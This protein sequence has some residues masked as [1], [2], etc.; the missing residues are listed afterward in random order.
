MK[1]LNKEILIQKEI[2]KFYSSQIHFDI[3]FAILQ[4]KSH[5]TLKIIDF[6]CLKYAKKYNISY[7]YT[8]KGKKERINVVNSYREQLKAYSGEYFT[9]F[10]RKKQGVNNTFLIEKNGKQLITTNAQLNFFA[11]CI[12]YGIIYYIEDNYQ[13]IINELN[14]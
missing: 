10:K 9:L 8:I 4:R 13:D 14:P 3:A 6:F 1:L 12:N 5:I 7:D 2:S 11:W